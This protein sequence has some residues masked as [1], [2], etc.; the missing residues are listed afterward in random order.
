MPVRQTL[1]RGDTAGELAAERGVGRLLLTHHK[2]RPDD[3]RKVALL[4]EVA[5]HFHDHLN[6]ATDDFEVAL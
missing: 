2:P 1:A 6:L 5:R 3:S 4:G